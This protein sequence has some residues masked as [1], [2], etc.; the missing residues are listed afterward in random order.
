MKENNFNENFFRP[1][2]RNPRSTDHIDAPCPLDAFSC[3]DAWWK[4]H[5]KTFADRIEKEYGKSVEIDTD[6]MDERGRVDVRIGSRYIMSA[7]NKEE[8]SVILKTAYSC[9]GVFSLVDNSSDEEYNCGCNCDC[10]DEMN[11]M[12]TM[13][14]F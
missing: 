5:I 10:K 7:K 2:P 13:F 1:K 4:R 12:L 11:Q 9:I 6:K 3:T 8:V 14:D